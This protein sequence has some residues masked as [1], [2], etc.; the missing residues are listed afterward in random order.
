MPGAQLS[1]L[2]SRAPFVESGNTSDLRFTSGVASAVNA[3]PDTWHGKHV[4]VLN[5]GTGLETVAFRFSRSS[6][7]T[8]SIDAAAADGGPNATRGKVLLPAQ[9]VRF[10]IPD[11]QGAPLYFARISASGTPAISMS[12]V[13]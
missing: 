10:V 3:I 5:E 12:L 1:A 13:E 6:I 9:A 11:G 8:A 2:R 7:A 4:E